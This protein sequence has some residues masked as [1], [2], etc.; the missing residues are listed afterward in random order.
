MEETPSSAKRLASSVALTVETSAQPSVATKPSRASRPT[1]TW[2]GKARHI[3]P[4]KVG[5][6]TALVPM[7]T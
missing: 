1:I 7:I 6:L 2:P 4:T 3:S 5:S